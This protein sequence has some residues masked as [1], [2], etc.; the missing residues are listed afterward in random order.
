VLHLPTKVSFVL[1]L[2]ELPLTLNFNPTFSLF[3]CFL[4]SCTTK[5]L[6]PESFEGCMRDLSNMMVYSLVVVLFDVHESLKF[7]FSVG[8][9]VNQENNLSLINYKYINKI[10]EPT[11]SGLVNFLHM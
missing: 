1:N 3:I 8:D 10:S 5:E 2:I 6:K 11:F 4:Q 7:A 9:I